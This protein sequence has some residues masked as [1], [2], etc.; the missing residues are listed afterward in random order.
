MMATEHKL[1][2]EGALDQVTGKI[3]QAVG[4]V[5][6]D[7]SEKARGQAEVKSW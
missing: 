2:T 6:Q 4:E 1:K 3:R 7:E 5:T